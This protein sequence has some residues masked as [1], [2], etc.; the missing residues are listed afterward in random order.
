LLVAGSALGLAGCGSTKVLPEQMGM[1]RAAAVPTYTALP[2]PTATWTP[3]PSTTPVAPYATSTPNAFRA[4]GVPVRLEIPAIGVD[5]QVEKVGLDTEGKVDVPKLAANV[6]WFTQSALPGEDGKTSV[7]SGHLDDPYGPAVFYDLRKLVPGDE[8]AVTYANG[9]R[10]IFVVEDK[11]R[12]ATDAVPSQ[13]I[14]GATPQRMLN[15]ITCDGA[16]S[17]GQA[18]YQ[19]RLVVYTRL[20]E[21]TAA[22]DMDDGATGDS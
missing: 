22:S 21:N 11:E 6:A 1:A 16:W 9:E 18:N 15:L 19:Q 3:L 4:A 13:K 17:S 7:I 5:S 10:F 2:A 14:F 8:M 12:Y 20:K